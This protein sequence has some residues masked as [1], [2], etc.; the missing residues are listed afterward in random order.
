MIP[1]RAHTHT[2]SQ[3]PASRSRVPRRCNFSPKGMR[4][5]SSVSSRSIHSPRGGE[6]SQSREVT[7][8]NVSTQREGP[9][10]PGRSTPRGPLAGAWL[11]GNCG[12][13]LVMVLRFLR[14]EVP[15]WLRT[16][17]V[18]TSLF[19][20]LDG[21]AGVAWWLAHDQGAAAIVHC[22]GQWPLC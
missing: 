22:K 20:T 18:P 16:R 1:K 21:G 9:T 8:D 5:H 14:A 15:H 10:A 12:H 6:G 19:P 3:R 7:W 4:A 13:L 17:P 2:R 11:G